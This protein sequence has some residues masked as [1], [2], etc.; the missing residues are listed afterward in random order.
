M[1]FAKEISDKVIF[2]DN[3]FIVEEGSPEDVIDNPKN[4]R[5]INFLSR[6]AK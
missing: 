1:N 6:V 4:E 5:T 3:G 2:M